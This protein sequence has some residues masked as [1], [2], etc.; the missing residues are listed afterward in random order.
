MIVLAA[1]LRGLVCDHISGRLLT[2][3]IQKMRFSKEICPSPDLTFIF[4]EVFPED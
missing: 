1:T 4:P 2:S 3:S